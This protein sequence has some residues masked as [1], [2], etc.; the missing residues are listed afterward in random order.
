M[1]S[2]EQFVSGTTSLK[3]LR[4]KRS[5]SKNLTSLSKQIENISHTPSATAGCSPLLLTKSQ[6]FQYN[7]PCSRAQ[8]MI[9]PQTRP[10][11]QIL[12]LES[13]PNNY[14][15][16]ILFQ[17][18]SII[19]ITEELTQDSIGNPRVIL[20]R[21]F[22]TILDPIKCPLLI[23]ILS[24]ITIAITIKKHIYIAPIK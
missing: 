24:N 7:A 15:I 6:T 10:E 19:F 9:I 11:L 23:S 22:K 18:L 14:I 20:F 12:L 13:G 5:N 21:M 8:Q 16:T 2:C 1:S 17:A 4:T 3:E